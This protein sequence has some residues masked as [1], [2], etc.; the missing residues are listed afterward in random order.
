M[1]VGTLQHKGAA[2]GLAGMECCRDPGD[3]FLEE[4][5]VTAVLAHMLHL[6]GEQQHCIHE[7]TLTLFKGNKLGWVIRSK[8]VPSPDRLA[9]EKKGGCYKSQPVRARS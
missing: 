4:I 8:L 2:R 1:W 9:S 3:S 7:D 5:K 6:L